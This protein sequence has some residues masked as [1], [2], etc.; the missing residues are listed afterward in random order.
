MIILHIED[1]PNWAMIVRDILPGETDITLATD[2][3]AARIVLEDGLGGK[4]DAVIVDGRIPGSGD[5]TP[6]V[7]A[8]RDQDFA[9]LIVGLSGDD[10]LAN[11]LKEA[12]CDSVVSKGSL[13]WEQELWEA[14]GLA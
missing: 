9:G 5:T 14:L 6:L 3:K 8:I 2:T 11:G 1:D 4:F 13:N 7:R 12:G 10:R